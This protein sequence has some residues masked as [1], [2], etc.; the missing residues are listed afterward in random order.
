MHDPMTVAFTIKYPWRAYPRS[1]RTDDFKKHYRKGFIT[2]WHVDPEA[3]G[4]D[5][6]C[7]YSIPHLNDEQRS[8]LRGL[9]WVEAHHPQFMTCRA[10]RWTGGRA[11]AEVAYRGLLIHVAKRAGIPITFDQAAHQASLDLH[12]PDCS[13]TA[14]VFC[15]LPGWHTTS[16]TDSLQDREDVFYARVCTIARWMLIDRRPWWRH[17]RWHIHHWRIQCHPLQALRRWLSGQDAARPAVAIRKGTRCPGGP[18]P[19]PPTPPPNK[20]KPVGL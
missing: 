4:S 18:R 16:E 10:K 15:F 14:N 20:T 6:S 5:D 19:S 2:V 11:E 1:E 13:D 3:D 12:Q 7:G 9:A 8:L 17:P